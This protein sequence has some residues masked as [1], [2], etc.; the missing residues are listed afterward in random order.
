MTQSEAVGKLHDSLPFHSSLCPLQAW[1][2]G[3]KHDA[4]VIAQG[5]AQNSLKAASNLV[6]LHSS[7]R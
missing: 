6:P 7:S 2:D 1:E 3:L 4:Y 5:V